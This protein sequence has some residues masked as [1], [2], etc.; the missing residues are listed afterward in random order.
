MNH[1]LFLEVSLNYPASRCFYPLWVRPNILSGEEHSTDWSAWMC[2]LCLARMQ[3]LSKAM[4]Y[5]HT[6]DNPHAHSFILY[7]LSYLWC[8]IL[9]P[10]GW[11]SL[12][13]NKISSMV[14]CSL[15]RVTRSLI[16][17]SMCVC[18]I[19]WPVHQLR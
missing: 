8:F 19:L 5:K 16:N 7:H 9:S 13:I 3:C 4:L 15:N 17:Q 1:Y 11:F 14:S 2:H 10:F 12:K 18:E 6:V